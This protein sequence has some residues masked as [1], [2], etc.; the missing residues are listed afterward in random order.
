MTLALEHIRH[1]ALREKI[2]T[3]N[4]AAEFVH[5]GMLVGM[6]GFTGAGYPKALP[7]AIAERAQAIHAEGKPFQ[8][9]VITGAS[10]APECDGVL[11]ASGSLK[12]R[13][14][15][16]SDPTLR[17]DINAGKI[18]YT[19]I[20]LSQIEQ[21]VRFGFFGAMDVA[22]IEIVGITEEGKLIP[23]MSVGPNNQWVKSAQ[24]IIL[25]VNTQQHAK[26]ETMHDVFPDIGTPPNRRP[27]LLL[28]PDDRIGS[29]YID[30]DLDKIVAVVFTDA[31]DRN[32]KFAEPDAISQRIAEQIIEFFEH[33]VKHGR[34]PENLLPLQSGVGNVANAV[35]AGLQHSRFE[36][37]TGFTEVLQDGMLDL[38]LS[39]KMASASATALSFS[40]DALQRFNDNID[41]LRDKIILRAQEI[42]NSPELIRRLGVIGMNAM[43]EADI[44]GNVNSTHI[45]GTRMMNGI[46]G[47]GDFA[48]NAYYSFFVS[49]SVAKDG[50]ISCIVPMVSHHDHTEH[51]VMFI[52]TE[53][54]MAD[55]RGK[56]PRQ[57]A[58]LIIDHC[59]HPDY[60]EML[61]DYYERA[62]RS[63][64]GLHTP[65]LLNEALSWHQRFV[66]TGNMRLK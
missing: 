62:E 6:S 63:G 58:R 2:M 59:A 4:E 34:L 16:Q 54:G 20:H 1:T 49:P 23:S 18:A 66:E 50:A 48:R 37:I 51:D 9:S 12:L 25:E 64:G 13:S 30:C 40:P 8:I 56:S 60:R 26:L 11:A 24:K 36:N 52:V 53:Q 17:N 19:D 28:N 38:L 31:P 41:F 39:G 42:T 21:Q 35:L 22:I 7:T 27:L 57:R 45:M 43:I 5:D 32:S 46:G 47:S 33:E 29:H 10:T 65:H 61:R 14:P 3:A 55:L 15:F 44:Y